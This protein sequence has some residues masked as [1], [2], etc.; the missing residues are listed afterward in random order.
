MV[1]E[2]A[3][4]A[5]AQVVVGA[6]AAVVWV[7]GVGVVWVLVFRW[8]A[9]WEFGQ[10]QLH[11]VSFELGAVVG[12]AAGAGVAGEALRTI[13]VGGFFGFLGLFVLLSYCRYPIFA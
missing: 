1:S 8:V 10:G 3:F 5:V 11:L 9:A 7:V 12:I 13:Y 6:V 4:E 2:L